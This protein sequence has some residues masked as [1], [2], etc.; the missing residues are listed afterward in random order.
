MLLYILRHAWAFE[1]DGQRWPNDGDRPLTKEGMARYRT[2]AR[3]LADR[4]CQPEVIGTSP[5]VRCRQ[6]AE[7]LAA[8]LMPSPPIIEVPALAPGVDLAALLAWSETQQVESLAWV[9]HAP[10]VGLLVAALIGNK[11]AEIR[12]AKG[13]AACI[14]FAGPAVAG[15]GEL[16]WHVT[17]K[18]LGC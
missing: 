9:G 4:G 13:A 8:E 14:R 18:L 1:Y 3:A 10:D 5:L 2:V 12:F 15:Q 11:F 17:A 16:Q 6:T 7:L